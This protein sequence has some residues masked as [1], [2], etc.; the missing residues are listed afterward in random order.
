MSRKK[1]PKI[2]KRELELAIW[3][4]E[5][6]AVRVKT[7]AKLMRI[8]K[9]QLHES[10]VR[11]IA[12]NLVNS[13]LANKNQI[14]SGSAILWPTSDALSLAKFPVSRGQSVRKPSLSQLVHSLVVSEIR[15]IYEANGATWICEK[16]LIDQYPN[17][18]PDGIAIYDGME[19]LVEVELSRKVKE[20]LRKILTINA[21]LTNHYVDYWISQDLLKV[22]NEQKELLPIKLQERVRSF[23]VP[24]DIL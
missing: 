10:R 6:G 19:I 22:F 2:S 18:R 12:Q 16:K 15:V 3:I 7:L 21:S 17:H 24:E 20:R 5:Q 23:I 13:N 11:R 8:E 4:A 9:P 1:S 14:L